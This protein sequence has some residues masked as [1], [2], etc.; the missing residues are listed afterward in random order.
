MVLNVVGDLL[1]LAGSLGLFLYGMRVMSDGLQRSAGERLQRLLNLMTGNRFAAF[2]TGFSVTVLLQSSSASTVLIV[3]FV[4]AGL[5]SLVQA[6]GLILGANVGTTVTGW[7]VAVFGFAIDISAAA[8]PAIAA[9]ALF[10]FTRRL[11]RYELGRSL[12]GFGLLFLGLMFLSDSVPEVDDYPAVLE[13]TA[14]IAGPGLLPVLGFVVVGTVLTIVLQ[15]SSAAVAVTLTMAYAGWIDFRMAAAIILGENIGTTITATLAS[16]GGSV[17]ARRAA[18]A[19]FVLNVIGVLWMLSVFEPALRIVDTIVPGSPLGIMLPTHLAVFHS[20][21]NVANVLLFIGFTHAFA[22]FIER[23]VPGDE[24]ERPSEGSV[25]RHLEEYM[26]RS[27]ELYLFQVRNELSRMAKQTGALY[28]R[29]ARLI[30]D[31]TLADESEIAAAAETEDFVDRME[32]EISHFLAT[33]SSEHL[34]RPTAEAVTSLLRIAHELER[35]ADSAYNLCLLARRASEKNRVFG[36]K[37]VK[38]L[39]KY[40]EIVGRFIR[41]TQ[42]TLNEEL[43]REELAA[44]RDNEE[45]VDKGRVSLKRRA[46]KRLQKHKNVKTELLFIDIVGHLEHIGDFCLNIAEAQTKLGESEH[47]MT[48]TA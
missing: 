25:L 18:R 21:F 43:T 6:I 27:P 31:P 44:A 34:A 42:R 35:I 1:R 5:L 14:S 7:I 45:A 40:V 8:L 48:R 19:H 9:G 13:F 47:D 46:R 20:L 41:F 30:L 3:G 17:G 10:Y 32:E 29:A 24:L 38:E 33:C 16:I 39:S 36:R 37:A 4:N 26:H 2:L 12:I 11:R 23:I 28:D 15:S 22:R